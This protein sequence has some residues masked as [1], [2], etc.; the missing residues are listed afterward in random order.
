MEHDVCFLETGLMTIE[1]RWLQRGYSV[2][3]V[4]ID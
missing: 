2:V 3:T 4:V 1:A